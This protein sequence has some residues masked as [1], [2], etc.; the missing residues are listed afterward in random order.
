MPK[1]YIENHI[2]VPKWRQK[3]IDNFL[4][5]YH[6][7]WMEF[8]IGNQQRQFIVTTLGNDKKDWHK[9]PYELNL[10]EP[11]IKENQLNPILLAT[12]E[13]WMP[14]VEY[15]QTPIIEFY[16]DGNIKVISTSGSCIDIIT[17][18]GMSCW[19]ITVT[20]SFCDLSNELQLIRSDTVRTEIP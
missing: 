10:Y 16:K 6:A 1:S 18:Q 4:E 14:H 11:N 2:D 17:D 20:N 12:Y 9:E 5:Y 7:Y 19:T 15:E 13:H 3:N 8:N